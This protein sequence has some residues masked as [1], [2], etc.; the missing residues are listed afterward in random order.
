[1]A[2]TYTLIRRT[3]QGVEEILGPTTLVD[4]QEFFLRVIRSK[5]PAY[6]WDEYAIRPNWRAEHRRNP[7]DYPNN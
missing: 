6:M 7:A 1:M 5:M 2:L 3:D 4:A